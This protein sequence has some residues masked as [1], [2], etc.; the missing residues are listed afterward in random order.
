MKVFGGEA[1][2]S[3]RHEGT[4]RTRSTKI[5]KH[6]DH[7]GSALCNEPLRALR[8][9]CSSSLSRL[10]GPNTFP[11]PRDRHAPSPN[12]PALYGPHQ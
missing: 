6:E 12:Q 8:V 11:V 3:R 9:S 4:R 1:F 7:E 2:G 10:R 5:T